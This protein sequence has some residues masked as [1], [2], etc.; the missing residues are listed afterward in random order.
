MGKERVWRVLILPNEKNLPHSPIHSF[1]HSQI[2][3][4]RIMKIIP[5]LPPAGHARKDIILETLPSFPSLS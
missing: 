5:L 1:I 4:R 3:I 2:H